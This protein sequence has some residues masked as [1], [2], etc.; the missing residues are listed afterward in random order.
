MELKCVIYVKFNQGGNINQICVKKHYII[1]GTHSINILPCLHTCC[2]K[3]NKFKAIFDGRAQNFFKFICV[4]KKLLLFFNCV[5]FCF[6]CMSG[7]SQHKRLC[8]K[9]QGGYSVWVFI[10]L[11]ARFLIFCLPVI[12]FV[13]KKTI[14]CQNI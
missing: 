2:K 11:S 8:N 6:Y 9:Q 5:K 3:N 4:L 13:S 1:L 14:V 7:W 10:Y 12:I